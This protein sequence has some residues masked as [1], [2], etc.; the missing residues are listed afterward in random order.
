M[1][2]LL[3][4]KNIGISEEEQAKHTT[5]RATKAEIDTLTLVDHHQF[6]RDTYIK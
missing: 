3:N 6:Y 5:Q 1:V 2:Q 4:D